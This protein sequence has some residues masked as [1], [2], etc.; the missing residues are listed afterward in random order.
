[1]SLSA[2]RQIIYDIEKDIMDTIVG[3][4]MFHAEDQDDN[5]ADCRNPTL[6]EV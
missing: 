5:D 2:E 3:D 4:M 1:L 6:R